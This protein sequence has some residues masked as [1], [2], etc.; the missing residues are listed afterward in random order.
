MSLVPFIL[1]PSNS[2]KWVGLEA[3]VVEEGEGLVYSC[4]EGVV[5]PA[6]QGEGA[7]FQG[8]EADHTWVVVVLSSLGVA[9]S[10]GEVSY[11][12]GVGAYPFQGH[13][14]EEAYETLLEMRVGEEGPVIGCWIPVASL[15]PQGGVEGGMA[16]DLAG[17]DTEACPCVGAWEGE[18]WAAAWASWEAAC[19]LEAFLAWLACLPWMGV[20]EGEPLWRTPS[21]RG[22]VVEGAGHRQTADEVGLSG[23]A[24]SAWP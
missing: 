1:L 23:T 14:G 15:E 6:Y 2:L 24:G 7:S 13:Q 19:F 11:L 8:V 18:A 5:V 20:G 3:G 9:S 12:E 21:V 17:V 4:L 22:A 16:S 10:L